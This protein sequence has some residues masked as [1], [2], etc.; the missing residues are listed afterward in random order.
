MLDV[1]DHAFAN[2]HAFARPDS[3]RHS[4]QVVRTALNKENSALAEQVYLVWQQFLNAGQVGEDVLLGAK[5]RAINLTGDPANLVLEN[6]CA[7]RGTL[8]VEQT[9]SINIGKWVYVGDDTILSCYDTISIGEGTLV[10]HGV[11]IFDNSSHPVN[12]FQRQVQ[13]MR[14][15][16]RKDVVLPTDIESAPVIVGPRCWIGMQSVVMRGVEIGAETI[17]AAGSVVTKSLPE[18]SVCAG[19]PCKVVRALTDQEL[20]STG[21][22]QI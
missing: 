8:R 18:R 2:A 13:F 11:Q 6:P 16:G 21:F 12:P 15:L 3:L 7:V 10:A 14:M 9:G 4:N 5:A 22:P 19:N 1:D 20:D 17:V